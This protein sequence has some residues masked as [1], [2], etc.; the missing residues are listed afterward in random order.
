MRGVMCER[1]ARG[2]EPEA[3]VE[4]MA[5]ARR[6]PHASWG[7]VYLACPAARARWG[8]WRAMAVALRWRGMDREGAPVARR[9]ARYEMIEAYRE[10]HPD[11]PWKEIYEDIG[12]A[13]PTAGA[14]YQGWWHWRRQQGR[15][16]PGAREPQQEVTP[17]AVVEN[18]ERYSA[19]VCARRERLGLLKFESEGER[20]EWI[21][22]YGDGEE[23]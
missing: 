5:V 9:E 7:E 12:E 16:V 15:P 8:N 1:D 19:K 21:R 2:D 11:K 22:R 6:M 4:A 17:E 20:A 18:I 3:V 14:M 23:D 10:E 13:W